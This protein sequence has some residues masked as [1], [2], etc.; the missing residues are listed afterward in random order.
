MIPDTVIYVMTAAVVVSAV[1]IVVQ[2]LILL[3]MYR[4]ARGLQEQVTAFIPKAESLVATAQSTL[5]QSRNQISDITTKA[6]DILDKTRVQ[7]G[8]ADE[9][10][11]DATTR[12]RV[13]MD[14]LE[15][16]FDD[17]VGRLHETVAIIHNGILA[18]L[19]EVNGIFSGIRAALG[20]L[21][22]GGRPTV[23]QATQDDEMFI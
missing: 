19:R 11:S 9:I 6:N 7:V 14:R 3:G 17:T 16:V 22:R 4:S 5:E 23:A 2:L 12:A 8:R 10:L 20:H 15:L 1:A 13:Q 21:S 18:P